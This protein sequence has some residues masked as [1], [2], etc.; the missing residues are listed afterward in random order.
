MTRKTAR[1]RKITY[2][3]LF[4]L[5]FLAAIPMALINHQA[6]QALFSRLVSESGSHA[7]ETMAYGPHPR[8]RLD[9]YTPTHRTTGRSAVEK[10]PI[11]LFL[12]G[13]GW[14]DGNREIYSFVGAALASR[15]IT[16]IIPD[17]RTYPEVSFPG[18]IEDAA[19]A[20]YWAWKNLAES[21]PLIVMGHS[22][23]AHSAAMIA[24]NGDYL[25]RLDAAI[26]RPAALIGISGPYSFDPTTWPSTRD[27]FSTAASADSARPAAHVDRNAPPALLLH[28]L[29]DTTVR[30]WNLETLSRNYRKAGQPVT[31]KT[32]P[33]L[34]HIDTILGIARPLRW[35]AP[36]FEDIIGFIERHSLP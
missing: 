26:G 32:Y 31:A 19:Q 25:A 10:R 34:A 21:R 14:R 18:F 22:A 9:I 20:Y 28:G 8:H 36:I 16:A 1:S 2:T 35:R 11:V 6:A 23:G 29:K 33:N 30:L 15:G 3:V 7:V 5:I 4:G 24:L 13:G 12:Y 27:I 17:Y